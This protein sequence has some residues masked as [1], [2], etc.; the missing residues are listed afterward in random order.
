VVRKWLNYSRLQK[1]SGQRVRMQGSGG[2]IS[3]G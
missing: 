1:E 3:A 2:E